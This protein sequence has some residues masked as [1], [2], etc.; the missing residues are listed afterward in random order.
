MNTCPTCQNVCT[1][2]PKHVILADLPRYAA[3]AFTVISFCICSVGLN[4]LQSGFHDQS[5]NGYAW[6]DSLLVA[7]ARHRD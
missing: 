1:Q 7:G 4:M 2:V 3:T 6:K 5:L